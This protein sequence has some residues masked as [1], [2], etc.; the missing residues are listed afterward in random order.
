LGPMCG[1]EPF[2]GFESRPAGGLR[3]IPPKTPHGALHS[4]D[5][6]YIDVDTLD[7]RGRQALGRGRRAY[8]RA[9]FGGGASEAGAR[10]AEGPP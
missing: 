7:V 2:L 10:G 1:A 5:A 8:S 3:R 6:A 4:A 9:C